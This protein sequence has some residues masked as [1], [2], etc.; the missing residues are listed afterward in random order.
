MREA[1]ASGLIRVA[2]E[3][4]KTNVADLLTKVLP[5]WRRDELIDTIM[6]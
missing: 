2:Y 4:T 5:A 3:P 6:F 1:V